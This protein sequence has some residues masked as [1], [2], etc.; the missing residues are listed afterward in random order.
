M[1]ARAAMADQEGAPEFVQVPVVWVGADEMPVQFVNQAMGVV[2]RDEIVLTLG[3]LVPP[4]IIGTEEE[5]RAQAENVQFIQI[6]PVARVGI[7]EAGCEQMIKVL[8]E[9]LSNFRAQPQPTESKSMTYQI[10]PDSR[11]TAGFTTWHMLARGA[12]AMS[13]A[14]TSLARS[15]PVSVPAD[16]L[17]YWSATWQEGERES[18]DDLAAG[19][20]D[21]FDDPTE[22]VHHLFRSDR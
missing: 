19:R 2:T 12:T 4:A 14:P 18:L 3:A 17:Y 16:Q 21:T 8:K 6:R 1:Y 7:T 22:A 10:A 13:L 11:V 5:R 20:V 15:M 9:S